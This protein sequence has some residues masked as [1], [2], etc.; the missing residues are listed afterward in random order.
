MTHRKK[1]PTINA[2]YGYEA[3]QYG[4]SSWMAK[5]QIQTTEEALNYL[6][7]DAMGGILKKPKENTLL[8]DLGCGTGY[9][10]HTILPSGFRVIGADLSWDMLSQNSAD[11]NLSRVQADLRNL[12]FRNNTMDIIISISAFNFASEGAKTPA[13]FRK[14]I[15]K[16]ID[17]LEDITKSGARIIIEFYPNEVEEKEFLRQIKKNS[18]LSGGMMIQSPQSRHEKKFLLLLNF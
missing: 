6:E 8:L 1:R 13:E 12:P 10:T 2:Y 18:K 11:H 3:E 16:A 9:S 5:N 15:K 14:F 17:G 4:I 7:S